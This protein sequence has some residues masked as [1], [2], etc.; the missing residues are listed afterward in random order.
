MNRQKKHLLLL[1]VFFALSCSIE[2]RENEKNSVTTIGEYFNIEENVLTFKS[3]NDLK[4]H[5]DGLKN[6]I[7]ADLIKSKLQKSYDKGFVPLAPQTENLQ[8]IEKIVTEKQKLLKHNK[9]YRMIDADGETFD[10][11]DDLILDD[12]FASFL[13][14]NREIIINDSLFTYTQAGIFVTH[15]SN[16]TIAR[17]YLLDNPLSEP[18][19]N[20]EPGTYPTENP[21]L[22]VVVPTPNPCGGISTPSL[23]LEYPPIDYDLGN[24]NNNINNLNFESCYSYN[25]GGSDCYHI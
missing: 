8:F 21:V 7:N 4:L 10:V 2:D 3:S 1:G 16:I 11:E 5:V 25:T 6:G 12:D 22:K 23:S 17:Q 19:T 9:S 20:I 14:V 18:I 24:K 15:K 13:N